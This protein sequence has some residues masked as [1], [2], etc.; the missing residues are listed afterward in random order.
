MFVLFF[1]LWIIFNGRITREICLIGAVLSM[2][3]YAFVCAF[4]GYSPRKDWQILKKAGV[5]L[6]YG[7]KLMRDIWMA[8]FTVLRFILSPKYRVEPRLVTFRTRLKTD[9][10]R[11]ILANS[12]TLTPGTITAGVEEDVFTVH[13]LDEDMVQGLK[14][15]P[16]EKMLLE[17]EGEEKQ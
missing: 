3:M 12:I 8:N 1:V 17:A 2:G 6:R 16:M 7:A 4:L 14:D 11:A 15:S 5:L 13:C 9:A 10:M